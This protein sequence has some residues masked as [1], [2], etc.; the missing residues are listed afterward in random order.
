MP[1]DTEQLV[2]SLEARIRDFERNFQ[3]AN[4][5][6]SQNFQAIERQAKRSADTLEQTMSKASSGVN[7]ALAGLKGGVAGIVA[8]LSIGALQGVV[9]RIGDITKGIANIGSEAKRAGLSTRAFQELGYVA[10]QNRIPIDALT[11]GMKE[12][13][14]R[15]DEFIIT[16]QGS[17]AEAFARLGYGA[18]DLKRKLQD[19]SALLVEIIGKLQQLDKAAQIR[20]ADELFGGTGGERFVELIDRGADGMRK[21]IKEGN[22]FGAVL[23]DEV[24]ARADELDRKWNAL[25]TT[26]STWT[27]Q[28]IL[29]LVGAMDDVLDRFNQIDEQS[30]RNVQSALT[31]VYSKLQAE[32]QTLADLMQTST[33]LPFEVT[34][35]RQS[36][37]EIERLTTEA[38]KLRDVLDSRQ[39]YDKDFIYKAGQ[40]AK[41]TTPELS[42][43]YGALNNTGTAAG[44]GAKGL[45]SFAEAVRALKN[46]IPDLANNLSQLDAQARINTAY[47]AALS[48]ARTMGEVYQAN[49]LR[50]AALKAV[51]VKSATDDPS[52]YLSHVLASGKNP[53][54]IMGMQSGF[55][56]KLA[57]MLASM[58]DDL[59]GSVTI[60]SG[61][62]SVERQQELWLQALQK[63]GSPE[64]ARKWVAPPGNSQ[65]N[66]GNAADLGYGS[67]AARQ[68]VHQNASQFGL[69]FPLA[70]ENWHIEDTEARGQARAQ[71]IQ[72]QTNAL[73]QQSEAYKSI[74]AD[75]Q[76]FTTAQTTEQQAMTMTGEAAAAYRYEQEMLAQAQRQG[77]TVNS[78]Q[79]AEI[80]QL[81]QGM[82]QAEQATTSFAQTQEQ[83]AEFSQMLGNTAVDALTGIL[84]GTTTAEQALAQL[85][86]QLI[87]VALQA[88]LLGQGP[89][90]NGGSG[91]GL[92]GSLFSFLFRANGG[93][94]KR[95]QLP[96]MA[97]GGQ[98]RGPGTSRSDSIPTMLSDGEFVVNARATD[99]NRSLL[100]A[101]NSGKAPRLDTGS[102]TGSTSSKSG[103]TSLSVGDIN[104]N[105]Q[106]TGSSGDAAKDNENAKNMGKEVGKAIDQHMT[107]WAINQMRPGGL[108]AGRR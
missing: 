99:K 90:G 42:N 23:D 10:Q 34:N 22:D 77:I 31:D 21:L 107:D 61:F 51:G 58:P 56:Q 3:R 69:S 102:V 73:M 43:L 9:S 32:K 65:H 55:Q 101:I 91:G 2:V 86:Q 66:K 19:P 6:S 95:S 16:G 4:R 105:V 24:I 8:G 94:V 68:W 37:Q 41:Q 46:E 39:G 14:L 15:A 1:T 35:I 30:T 71:E 72:T 27:K 76:Q 67:D 98:V 53:Q 20:I 59:K 88:A 48:K 17:A 18:A 75:A 44:T 33:G 82:A 108:L 81:A 29:G 106:S 74:I 89:L 47:N 54:H 13:S 26:I 79:R 103:G 45:N 49:E 12:L 63:Y 7:V 5:T 25:G 104:V 40:D 80:Q 60:N 57:T 64:A 92:F 50:G 70:N 28:A 97:D 62:R 38:M 85:G 93:I 87:K 36:Q 78:Q 11:D 84:T 96:H 52:R 100:E 83:A